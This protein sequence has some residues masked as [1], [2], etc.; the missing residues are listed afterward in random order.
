MGYLLCLRGP[1]LTS[2]THS[3]EGALP[4]PE[5]SFKTWSGFSI[6]DRSV[7]YCQ[8]TDLPLGWSRIRKLSLE[9]RMS[10][11]HIPRVL[12]QRGKSSLEIERENF[13][14]AQ[15][16]HALIDKH[17]HC[18][19]LAPPPTT[20]SRAVVFDRVITDDIAVLKLDYVR[21]KNAYL[22]LSVFNNIVIVFKQSASI[23]KAI[24]STEVPAKEKH[25]RGILLTSVVIVRFCTLSELFWAT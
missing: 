23:Q 17:W 7:K 13:E 11:V 9:G 20:G 4:I 16:S 3:I 6:F 12:S 5:F 15:V 22:R 24:N 10:S 2:S 18:H 21:N 1:A 25:V 8:Q 19:W 14:R